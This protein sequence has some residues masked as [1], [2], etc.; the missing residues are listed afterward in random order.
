[1]EVGQSK[2]CFVTAKIH[3]IEILI[4]LIAQ[5]ANFWTAI[6]FQR[7]GFS[8]WLSYFLLA[9]CVLIWEIVFN[10]ELV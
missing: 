1:M 8:F 4:V 7:L 2:Y 10:T 6:I 3:V 5:G 9:T